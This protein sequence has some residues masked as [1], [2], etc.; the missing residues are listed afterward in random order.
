MNPQQIQSSD[1][2]EV[3]Q[4][5]VFLTLCFEITYTD[6]NRAKTYAYFLQVLLPHLPELFPSTL[7]QRAAFGPG[8]YLLGGD[9]AEKEGLEMERREAEVWGLAA[10]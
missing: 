4:W 10:A 1:P 2:A 9:T 8:A 7:A 6:L 5:R 3:E